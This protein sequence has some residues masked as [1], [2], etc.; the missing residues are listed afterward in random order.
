ML[1]FDDWK[2]T[3]A[4]KVLTYFL[5][6][7]MEE[8]I[9]KT[10]NVPLM[11]SSNNF[12]KRWRALG[13]GQ[14]GWH[15][16]LQS[17]MIAFESFEANQLCAISSKIIDEQSL[18]A[19]KELAVMFGEPESMKGTGERNLTRTAIAPTTSSSFIHGQVSPSIE[20]LRSNYFTK[21]LAKG[22]FTYKNPYL[23]KL[24]AEKGKDNKEVWHEILIKDGS[25]Q[26]LNFLTQEEK[27]VFKTFDEIA[28]INIVQQASIR[29]KFIDQSQSLNIMIPHTAAIKDVNSLLIEGWRLGVKTFYYQRSSNPAQELVR[30]IMTCAACEA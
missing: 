23:Q 15:S 27:D 11:V 20:P 3:D 21:D 28:P 19:T 13:I 7:V 12:A 24:L 4:V 30:D 17:K 29:Q 5:D 22:S 18:E 16:Y 9:E 14:L 26:H 1:F 6:A 2:D 10:K 25:V 8:Y